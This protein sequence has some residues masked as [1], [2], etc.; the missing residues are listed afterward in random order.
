M[1]DTGFFG[2][3]MVLIS[4]ILGFGIAELV[5]SLG[6]IVRNRKD[7]TLSFALLMWVA[8]VCLVVVQFWWAAWDFSQ[9]KLSIWD[10]FAIIVATVFHYLMTTVVL[11]KLASPEVVE[12][13]MA[14]KYRLESFYVRNVTAMCAAAVTLLL[15]II[16]TDL[17][18]FGLGEESRFMD[19]LLH[20]VGFMAVLVVLWISGYWNHRRERETARKE[21]E[22]VL[23]RG[24]RALHNVCTLVF[25]VLLFSF[26]AE[27]SSKV[28]G[29]LQSEDARPPAAAKSAPQPDDRP[30]S[31]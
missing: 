12:Q 13:L 4:I 20:R 5:T 21:A 1:L 27:H 23:R 15:V 22:Y 18:V 19:K 26:I 8:L 30:S 29:K 31:G 2:H 28:P 6:A 10:Y 11:P 9:K 3:L 16:G 25:A 7:V 14:G 24:V 17:W